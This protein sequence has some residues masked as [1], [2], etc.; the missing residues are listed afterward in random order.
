MLIDE[1]VRTNIRNFI[2][3]IQ[4]QKASS[5]SKIYENILSEL[6]RKDL[7]RLTPQSHGANK[8]VAFQAASA[9]LMSFDP[10][11]IAEQFTIIDID[12]YKNLKTFEFLDQAWTKRKLNCLSRTVIEMMDRINSLSYWVA[13]NILLI[14]ELRERKKMLSKIIGMRLLL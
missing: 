6:D 10:S 4:Q 3:F 8:I 1:T 14:P 2:A 11:I 5:Y 13:T 12:S 9:K 7:F